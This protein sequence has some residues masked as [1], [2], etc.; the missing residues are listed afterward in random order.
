MG[1]VN[2]AREFYREAFDQ[3]E[4][5]SNSSVRSKPAIV[6]RTLNLMVKQAELAL[7][8]S[9]PAWAKAT[10]LDVLRK[11][12]GGSTHGMRLLHIRSKLGLAQVYLEEQRFAD[13]EALLRPSIDGMSSGEFPEL[14]W[15]ARLQMGRLLAR[16]G[17]H[18]DAIAELE[19]AVAILD[20]LRDRI[21]TGESRR[22]F[23]N[24]RLD[25]HRDLV[26]AMFHT[27]GGGKKAAEYAARCKTAG[28]R[29]YLRASGLTA[30]GISENPSPSATPPKLEGA[31]VLDYFETKDEIVVFVDS[32]GGFRAASLGVDP[33]RLRNQV[34]Q[35]VESIRQDN[36]LYVCQ[37]RPET[38]PKSPV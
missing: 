32:A 20:T 35:F 25:A 7:R 8:S 28:L 6:G 37:R 38:V 13:A 19:S 29:D 9:D 14:E 31:A 33:N 1:R 11:S 21:Q 23:M 30:G 36:N 12:E 26:S 4:R 3:N 15:Q 10:F 18:G 2:E 24:S 34:S 16:I 5:F 22:L 27:P 17:R